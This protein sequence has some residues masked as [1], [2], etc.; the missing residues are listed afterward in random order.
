MKQKTDVNLFF[1]DQVHYK[2]M[3]ENTCSMCSHISYSKHHLYI[4]N[5]FFL[6]PLPSIESL[7]TFFFISPC[8]RSLRIWSEGYCVGNH[9]QRTKSLQIICLCVG[10]GPQVLSGDPLS[11]RL[12]IFAWHDWRGWL[13]EDW[14]CVGAVMEK[15]GSEGGHRVLWSPHEC[16]RRHSSRLWSPWGKQVY[17]PPLKSAPWSMFKQILIHDNIFCYCIVS[18]WVKRKRD[19]LCGDNWIA[20]I[21][22][23]Q[24]TLVCN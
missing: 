4:L 14:A 8:K 21:F 10:A 9:V 5:S 11:E 18:G 19:L 16:R 23:L 15:R 13:H 1:H 3:K 12:A 2:N 20:D 6:G 17:F 24:E 22:N 7:N